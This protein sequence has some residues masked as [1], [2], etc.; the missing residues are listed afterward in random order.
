MNAIARFIRS[1]RGRITL[2][3]T[4]MVA[5][6]LVIA[7]IALVRLVKADLLASTEEALDAA[8]AAQAEQFGDIELLADESYDLIEEEIGGT[9]FELGLFTVGDEGEAL[10]DL[11]IE[12]EPVA[13]LALDLETGEVVEIIDPFTGELL[14]DPEIHREL[15]SLVFEVLELSEAGEEGGGGGR[16]LVGAAPLREVEESVDALSDALVTVVPLLTVIFGLLT[17]WLVGRALRPVVSITEQVEEIS[18]SNLHRRVPVPETADE[19]AEMATVMNTMLARLERGGERQRQFSADASHELRSPLST[20]R[21]AADVLARNPTPERA[22]RLADD[23]AA[24]TER[25]DILIGDLLELARLDEARSGTGA[26]SAEPLDLVALV[27][28]ELAGDAV[29]LDAP[30]RL[31]MVGAPRQLARLVRNLVDN[32]KRHAADRVRVTIRSGAG[33]PELEVD[34]D[35]PGVPPGQE[36]IIFERFSRLDEARSRDGGGAG[37]GLSLVRSIAESH[38]GEVRVGRSPLGGARFTVVL[39]APRAGIDTGGVEGDHT[40]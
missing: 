28:S 5:I 9:Q 39:P 33:G 22:A 25:M 31:P 19:V 17:W 23:I 27:E 36:Q 8:L 32:A 18:T 29:E 20:V 10:G 14:D 16:L 35:G 24:E 38:G 11:F 40:D 30:E 12:G 7:S 3:S 2:L 1:V 26:Q 37:L 15:E 21:A 13:Q 6:T 34:D 4:A